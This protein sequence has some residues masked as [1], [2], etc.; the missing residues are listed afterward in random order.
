MADDY[1]NNEQDAPERLLIARLRAH[2]IDGEG[3]DLLP[4][5]HERDVKA[6]VESLMKS[7]AESGFLIRGRFVYPW[8]QVKQIE[9]TSVEEMPARL[10]RQHFEELFA[11]ERVRTQEDFWRTRPQ[12]P[13]QQ[14]QNA[15]H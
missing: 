6:E 13:K 5:Q 2:L 1:E 12:P 10:A 9:V 3:F 8:H 15:D 11:A 14:P 4:I 7:W